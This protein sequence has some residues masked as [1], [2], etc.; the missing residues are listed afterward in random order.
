MSSPPAHYYALRRLAR[1]R[2][3]PFGVRD[4]IMRCFAHPD[5][6][7]SMAF[8][9][10]LADGRWRGDLA[11]FIDW[12]IFFY[13]AYEP[14][15]RRLLIDLARECE[16]PIFLDIGANFGI[17]TL[18]MARHCAKVHAFEPWEPARRRLGELIDMNDLGNVTLHPIG[19]G[20]I[21]TRQTFYAPAGRN[22]GGGSFLKD[23][24]GQG[25]PGA[26]AQQV[27]RGDDYLAAHDID[28]VDLIKIDVEGFEPDVLAGLEAVL[29]RCRPRILLEYSLG[30]R[31]RFQE[32]AGG[33]PSWLPDR[34]EISPA[35]EGMLLCRPAR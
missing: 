27:E 1:L 19:L 17:H 12:T 32:R 23:V 26:E 21:T 34:Y 30:A 4:R 33:L 2:G 28:K 6:M 8:E 9:D 10:L 5:R 31:D 22:H 3:L 14:L 24:N 11:N 13:G 29:R 7:P 35:P 16:T 18:A 20:A 15:T 25:V